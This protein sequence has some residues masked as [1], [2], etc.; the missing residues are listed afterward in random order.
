MWQPYQAGLGKVEINSTGDAGRDKLIRLRKPKPPSG[1]IPLAYANAQIDDY[2]DLRRADFLWSPPLR[3]KLRARF[4]HPPAS[5]SDRDSGPPHLTG[6]AG[7]GFWND[8]FV[9]TGQSKFGYGPTLPRALW[10]FYASPP[11]DMALAMDV[12]GW[13]W[14][15]AVIDCFR[16]AFYALLP[17][18]PIGVLLMRSSFLYR[19][20]WPIAQAAMNVDECMVDTSL[21]VWRTYEIEWLEKGVRFWVDGQ[22]VFATPR[23]PRG[24][25]GM[26]IWLDNQS[27]VVTPTGRIRSGLVTSTEDELL[28]IEN[29][30]IVIPSDCEG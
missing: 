16:P 10:F 25:L 27:M 18:A 17:T 21:T 24:P 19:R 28:E 30:E 3:L 12:P 26:V 2:H 23:S 7:F 8:P 29:L 1:D 14:K 11:S 13:G 6:T 20:L 4:S 9:M 5:P 15:A 22:L